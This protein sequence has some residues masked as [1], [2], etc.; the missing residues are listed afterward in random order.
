M[1][2]AIKFQS[3]MTPNELIPNLLGPI[4][5]RIN[6]A[7][8]LWVTNLLGELREFS[9]SANGNQLCIY[10]GPA[11]PLREQLQEPL[12]RGINLTP[13]EAA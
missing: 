12:R 4:E 5:G 2:H 8:M 1:V 9:H 10:R 13:K 6:D 11:Y 7:A 3:A